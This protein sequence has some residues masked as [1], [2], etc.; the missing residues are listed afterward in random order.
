MRMKEDHMRNGQLKPAYNVQ[1]AVHS[2]YIMG[3]GVF[4]KSND[5]NTLIPFIQQLEEIHRHRF[6]YVVADAG[7]DSH[8]NLIWLKNNHY[9]SCIKP[10][11]YEKAKTRTWTK[12]TSKARNMEYI[13]EEDAF[14]CAKGRKLKYAFTRKAENKT[15][16]VSERKVYI[17]ESCNRC[18]YK[19]ECQRYVKPTTENPVKRIE[20]TPEYDTVL[21]ENQ[22]RLLSDTGIQLRINR[23]IQVEGAFG[24]LKQDLGFRRLLHRGSGNVH[25]MLYLL[26]MGFNL[27]KL[28]NRIQAG[29]VNTTLFTA[30][31]T[32]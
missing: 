6:T 32:A 10:Q 12:D 13:P 24:V 16:F 30:K 27:A 1:L 26:S 2:E 14:T 4:S 20:I 9:L 29:R 7:Y 21:A 15:G 23:S 3:I 5:T 19:K 17:C 28:H 18:G 11:Y 25:K 31:E 22:D 8:E